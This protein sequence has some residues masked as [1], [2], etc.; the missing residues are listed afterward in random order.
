MKGVNIKSRV[1][2]ISTL[3]P[4]LLSL[5][6]GINA[7]ANELLTINPQSPWYGYDR[8]NEW[9]FDLGV[10]VEY[11]PSYTGSS[12]YNVGPSGLARAVYVNENRDRYIIGLGDLGAVFSLSPSTQLATFVEYE[13]GRDS[14][15]DD[16]LNGLNDIDATIE[17]QVMLAHRIGNM[18]VFG[19]LQ[20]DLAGKA[21]KGVVWF[22]GAGYDWIASNHWHHSAQVNVSGGDSEYMNT[23][24]GIT[25]EEAQRTDYD[26]YRL[27]SGLKSTTLSL[28]SEYYIGHAV[29]IIGDISFEYYLDDAADS[30]L[31]D[32]AGSRFSSE[33]SVAIRWQF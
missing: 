23:E 11:E 7:E 2:T 22:L 24:F 6:V 3:F 14:T 19:I 16:A 18:T 21:N 32:Q 9:I 30:P 31:I 33:A 27:E 15:D 12:S 4:I 5:G 26:Q 8:P 20:P 28:T 1:K 29:S 13:E 17:G 10:G 25:S